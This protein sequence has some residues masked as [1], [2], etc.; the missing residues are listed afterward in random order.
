MS[1]SV[2]GTWGVSLLTLALLAGTSGTAEA[3]GTPVD[4]ALPVPTVPQS[5]SCGAADSPTWVTSTPSATAGIHLSI[6]VP[7]PTVNGVTYQGVVHVQDV[8]HPD[9]QADGSIE[10]L[11]VL[12]QDVYVPLTLVDGHTYSWSAQTYDGTAYSSPTQSCYFTVDGGRPLV[13]AL[14]DPDYPPVGS[15]GACL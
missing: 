11:P 10:G 13:T 1:R 2:R 12:S 14:T 3:E 15:G 6:G 5:E 4:P 8:N 9:V 7:R